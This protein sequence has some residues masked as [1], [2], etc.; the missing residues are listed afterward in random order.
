MKRTTFASQKSSSLSRAFGA[1][2][3]CSSLLAFGCTEDESQGPEGVSKAIP[4]AEMLAIKVPGGQT[5]A[6]GELAEHYAETRDISAE[7]N[8]STAWALQQVHALLQGPAQLD[9]KVTSWGPWIGGGVEYKTVI[10]ERADGGYDYQLMART[11]GGSGAFE[12]LL[13]GTSILGADGEPTKGKLTIDFEADERVSPGHRLE[14]GKIAIDY[15]LALRTRSV[16]VTSRQGTS[17]STVR[18]AYKGAADGAG[19]LL[20]VVSRDAASVSIRSRWQAGG[21]GRGDARITSGE[22]GQPEVTESQCWDNQYKLTYSV[23]QVG[24]IVDSEGSAAS[25]V[26]A[27]AELPPRS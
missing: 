1:T 21:A 8:S 4:T 27:S 15:D 24:T 5:R 3:L 11:A 6:I 26:F 16:E 7:I 12:A 10:T 18:H 17:T 22:I 2:L 19:E 20:F 13:S 14:T 23:T 9:G 25:C